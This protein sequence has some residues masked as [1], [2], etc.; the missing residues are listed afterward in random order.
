MKAGVSTVP[1]GVS[2][3][4]QRAA[5]VPSRAPGRKANGIGGRI[6]HAGPRRAAA[7]SRPG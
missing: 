1:R 3:A 2:I 7:A 6:Y 5:V 4:P